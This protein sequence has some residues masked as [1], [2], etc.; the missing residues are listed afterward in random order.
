MIR[1]EV[2]VAAPLDQTLTYDLDD[3]TPGGWTPDQSPI[4]R[5]VLVPL[6]GRSLTGYVLAVLLFEEVEYAIRRVI[7]VLDRLPLFHENLLPFFRWASSYYHYPI[8]QVIKTALPA[9]LA[10]KSSRE[11]LLV[12]EQSE[13]F[14]A[15]F[16]KGLPD[17]AL[18]LAEAHR[19]SAVDTV[20]VL[21]SAATKKVVRALIVD[22][23][24]QLHETVS[25]DAVREKM[26]ICY[27]LS[28]PL[29]SLRVSSDVADFELIADSWCRENAG[30][31]K[32]SERRTLAAMLR[33]ASKTQEVDIPVKELCRLYSGARK[34]IPHLLS[35]GLIDEKERRVFRN[36]FGEPV[37]LQM[38]PDSLTE[39]QEMALSQI[40]PAVSSRKY[41]T[42]L[43]HGVTGCGK[44]E[45]Y[46][47]AAEETLA[48]GRDV[49]VL[50]PE[51]ALATQL[52]EHF[53]SRF[54]DAVVLLHSG[55]S[56]AE[57]FDQWF[58]ALTGQARIVIGARS[59]IF[60]PLR[61]PGLIVVDEEHDAGF[62]QDDSFRYH[63]RDLAVLRGRCHEA[64]VLLGSATPS[65]TSSY[66]ARTGKY[67][68]LQ[69]KKRVGER[70]LPAVTIVD[71]GNKDKTEGKGLF[72]KE[73]RQALIENLE[74]GSQSVLLLNRRGFSSVMLCQECGAPVECLH[75]RVSLTLHKAKKRLICHYCG[76]SVDYRVICGNCRSTG[77]LVPVGFGTERVEEEAKLLLPEARIARLDS[78]TAA[79][80]KAFLQILKAMREREIDVLI[81][82]QMIAK[83]HHFPYVTLVGV[84]WA[85][86]GLNMPDFRAAEK[87]FQ[88]IT[89]VTGRAGRGD[90][91]GRVIIQTMRPDHYSIRFAQQHQYEELY[92][93]E[94]GIRKSPAFPPF[95]RLV[96]LHIQGDKEVDV[97]RTAE[98]IADRC[99]QETRKR[100][101]AVEI[102][103]P[104]PAPLEKL[105]QNYRWQ[106]LLK[107]ADLDELHMICRL[108]QDARQELT[109]GASRIAIDV[110]P[111]NMM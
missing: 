109:Q 58:L 28:Q 6:G 101:A 11:I 105:K 74:K 93:H 12:D 27:T 31:L 99:R 85:D 20:K 10:P 83:G 103:G 72:R 81:G 111:E 52:E 61:D 7:K 33:L 95:V 82:T 97:R 14:R 62:K 9:G 67:S 94:L 16:A 80:R 2:A 50:V 75:C 35:Q 110:D 13:A 38:R 37:T 98:N 44:T 19:L 92:Q 96:A 73:L 84:V 17:W 5:R 76:Y 89:Q 18:R 60:A 25:A 8:G 23:I 48:R 32:V 86:G 66:H 104:A 21:K 87:T 24:L 108:V 39:E 4:G 106:V 63:G 79:D 91:P 43:L 54:G 107:A 42:F 1:V 22:G 59:A 46:L 71:L 65:V 47:Q 78:D 55:L 40:L 100:K 45:I 30:E 88:L 56:A 36:P 57:K 77:A 90:E 69:M 49:L 51:I 70:L 53:L 26:E 64:V 68:L 3:D 102:L 41:R 34:A 15:F 29:H